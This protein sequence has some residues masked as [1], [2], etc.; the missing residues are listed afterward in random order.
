MSLADWGILVAIVV[1]VL[2]ILGYV[3]GFISKIINA[4]RKRK[5]K[6][7]AEEEKRKKEILDEKSEHWKIQ[8]RILSGIEKQLR[9]FNQ[10]R[11]FSD[12]YGPTKCLELA[13]QIE[14]EI[15]KIDLPEFSQI[16]DKLLEYAGRKN[17][18]DQNT[19]SKQ[20]NDLFCKQTEPNKYEPFVLIQKIEQ[21]LKATQNP[22]LE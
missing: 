13:T 14:T 12:S 6:K 11:D 2:G 16:K 3:T 7:I 4:L 9:H 15:Q 22:P 5:E 19:L 17:K 18:I 21:A 10:M 20:L 1:G 8:R